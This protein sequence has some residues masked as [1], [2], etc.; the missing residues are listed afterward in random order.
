MQT[1]TFIKTGGYILLTILCLV[2]L[3]VLAVPVG[4]QIATTPRVT[5]ALLAR[6][7][8]Q[9]LHADAQVEKM[10]LRLWS[11][12]PDA[13]LELLQPVVRV[14]V[15]DSMRMRGEQIAFPHGDT[16]FTAD[17]L[18]VRIHLLPLT[19]RHVHLRS[20]LLSRPHV[21]L[22]QYDSTAN[23]SILPPKDEQDSTASA[24]WRIEWEDVRLH[25]GLVCMTSDSLDILHLTA[26]SLCLTSN[27]QYC[28]STLTAYV[29]AGLRC[30]D[31]HLNAKGLV[32]DSLDLQA[33]LSVP[34][35]E[36]LIALMPDALREKTLRQN[37]LQ[38]GVYIDATARGYYTNKRIPCL[39]ANVQVDHL[40][41][42]NPNIKARLENLTLRGE[43]LYDPQ[44]LNTSFV[45]IDTLRFKSG[46][47]RLYAHGKA[48]YKHDREWLQLDL[49][50]RLHLKELIQLAGLE[51]RVRA[52][53]F[54][55]ADI[56]TYFYLDDLR[57]RRIYD[58]HSAS[59]IQ[60]DSVF[61]GIR[62][63]RTRFFMDSLRAEFKT[64]MARVSRRTGKTDTALLN[65]SMAFRQMTV[66]YRRTTN[67][68]MDRV[69]V[70]L[71]ADDLNDKTPPVLH[72]S[73]S[74]QG[75]DAQQYDTIRLRAKRLRVSAGMR[76][77]TSATFVPMTTARISMDSVFLSNPRNGTMVDSLRVTI[78]TTPRYRRFRYDR[79]TKTRTPIPDSEHQPMALDS[80]LRLANRV[81]NDTAPA[82]AF[83]RHFRTNG[84][85]YV[86]RM[87]IRHKGDQLRPTASR[88]DLTLNDD[89][90][91]LNSFFL[92]VGRSGMALRGDVHHLRRYLLRGR[93]LE[94]NLS[95][96]S[97]RIDLN[98]LMN[99]L[100]QQ[101]QSK[102]TRDSVAAKENMSLLNDT[103]M[104]EEMTA[105]TLTADTLKSQ[106]LVLP[107]NLHVTFHAS[108]DTV[109]V[110]EMRLNEFSGDV[111][112]QDNA[113]SVTNMSTST[114]VGRMA[115]NMRYT[116]RDSLEA[117]AAASIS[118]DSVQ[119]GELIHYLP[120]LDSIMP[121]LRSF[122]GSVASEMAAQVRL[123]QDFSIDLPS[124]NA[125]VWLRGE[126]LVLM[127]GET[128]SEIAKK[129]MFSKKTRNVI[130]SL[131]VEVLVKNNEVEIFPFMLSMDKYRV[132]VGGK[133]NLDGSFNY[134]ISVFKPLILGLDVY[135]ADFGNIDFKL[136]K[137][138]YQSASSKI[139]KGGSLL[140]REDANVIPNMQRS[141][142]SY[143][144]ELGK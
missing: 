79:Q 85:I 96:R 54:V 24:P 118:M 58:I 51:Q 80:L 4:L 8:P 17:T 10:N 100:A 49:N 9:F 30:E 139:G 72:A 44:H 46:Q 111:H 91:R 77:D 37:Q 15:P 105:D 74:L 92:R 11:T 57:Q 64:N 106:L 97:R 3:L 84:K 140:R 114:K 73:L 50:A 47:S 25:D 135:G 82:E 18:R 103:L 1:N 53:G 70:R 32:S 40:H 76:P 88:I 120:E 89:S 86:R 127:D 68:K 144:L 28:D 129:L 21:Y 71:Y 141:I 67:A 122:D 138:R 102:Q 60:G 36:H 56:A 107:S 116:C 98:Q 124:V 43:A 101:Q 14:E 113:L 131:S 52:R 26:D 5:N 112:L 35:V 6:Y 142:Q 117:T 134:H 66:K 123:K 22:V 108:V 39:H 41:G 63:L 115:V 29:D 27:G 65:A 34:H 125:G 20:L 87:G 59:T 121:M 75:V 133:Q 109:I 104:A 33:Q 78:S 93:T 45:R 69:R 55:K 31:A 48:C 126:D 7:V 2:A 83:I 95:L 12:F 16:L 137:P 110:S 90:V 99:A 23:Y 42:G 132:G 19:N 128:F 13:E 62:E 143:I 61:V 130:D 136:V 81:V 119:V 38:G 94:A